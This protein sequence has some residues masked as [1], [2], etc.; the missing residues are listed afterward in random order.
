MVIERI[1]RDLLIYAMLLLAI[2]P[3]S[4]VHAQVAGATLSGTVTDASRTFAVANV[5]QF[6]C[7]DFYC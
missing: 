7:S 6:F 3:F 1:V 4:P 5:F 2:A